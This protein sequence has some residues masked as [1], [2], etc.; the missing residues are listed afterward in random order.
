M[1]Q[2]VSDLD[3][4]EL[5]SSAVPGNTKAATEWGI[6]IWNDWAANRCGSTTDT[7]NGIT[8]VTTPL[9]GMTATDLNYWMRKL[10]LEVRKKDGGMYPLKLVCCFKHYYEAN[11]VHDINPLDASDTRLGS[12]R[13]VLDA[14]MKRL[15]SLGLGATSKQAEPITS[16]DEALLWSTGQLGTQSSH[17]PLNTVYYYNCKV[18][19][20]R[21]YDE[22][23]NLLCAQYEKK[24]DEN[25]D[26]YLQ[27]TDFGSKTTRG[28]LKH[29]KVDNK[30][31]R[32]YE[33]PDNYEHCVVEKYLSL[34]PSCD[35]HFYYRP[36]A[37][38]GC[39]VPKFSKQVVG[40]NKLAQL[41][42]NMCKEAGIQG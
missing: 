40:R 36:L 2:P 12:F 22:H 15:H 16:D 28:G 39:G 27:Y 24:V 23:R 10:V 6:R 34:I 31:I 37:N 18:F 42:P 19:G 8:P 25:G 3:E 26:V 32:Q 29:M 35:A 38:K 41:I 7:D 30:V 17:S 4:K 11:G 1:A 13:A 9:L 33:N 5:C 20:L 21:S 14:E